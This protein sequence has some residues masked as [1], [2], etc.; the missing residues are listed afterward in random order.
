MIQSSEV[1]LARTEGRLVC[2]N[3]IDECTG[4]AVQEAARGCIREVSDFLAGETR[5]RGLV[6][7]STCYLYTS[8]I[9]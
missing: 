4:E 5:C 7:L 3:I 8:S 9:E 1:Q 6:L 2:L